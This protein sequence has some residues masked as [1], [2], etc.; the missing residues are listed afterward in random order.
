MGHC[1]AA[2]RP[3]RRAR[4]ARCTCGASRERPQPSAAAARAGA[5]AAPLAAVRRR[6]SPRRRA[7]Q[8]E[9]FDLFNRVRAAGGSV[10]AAGRATPA[11]APAARGPEDAPARRSR[12]PA[13]A[14][15]RRGEGRGAAAH[16][17]ARGLK[18]PAEVV[19][20]LLAT[21]QRDLASCSPCS[22]RSTAIR[23]RASARLRCRW[24]A[25]CC[26]RNRVSPMDLIAVR[27]R[28]HAARRR[29]RLR[30]GAVPDRAGR[31]RPRALRSAERR[32]LRA[33]QGRHARHPRFPRLPA[34][35]ARAPP[36]RAA[37]RLAR[38]IHG[39]ENPAYHRAPR[40]ATRGRAIRG[41]RCAPS[42]PPPTR[43]VTAPIAREF[44]VAHLIATEPEHVAVTDSPAK[45][46]ARPAFA[47]AR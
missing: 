16:A 12:V 38:R 8:V 26:A 2:A 35:A 25:K 39:R 23:S 36:A 22:T 4:R 11:R 29:Q 6:G 32:I 42:S 19:A 34:G 7:A 15:R 27:S 24:C 9:A 46:S 5:G 20:Y 3:A 10:I 43:F 17:A 30:M 31:A 47:K 41:G 45:L 13:A 28:Q 33:V 18:L 1:V 37:R 21:L 44:G 40:R 14:A